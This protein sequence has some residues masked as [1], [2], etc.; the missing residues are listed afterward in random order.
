[1]FTHYR[2]SQRILPPDP[3]L[4]CSPNPTPS[5]GPIERV[6][7]Q[8]YNSP[9]MT[10]T[11]TAHA[12]LLGTLAVAALLTA[13]CGLFSSGPTPAAPSGSGS[14][15]TTPPTAITPSPS[16]TPH[17]VS[18]ITLVATLGE[19]KAATPAGLTWAGIQA[20]AG[21]IGATPTLV[22]PATRT[23]LAS[24]IDKAAGED[25]AVV[26]TVDSDATAAVLAAAASHPTTQFLEVGVTVPDG[27]PA[28]VHGL[29][30]DEAEAGYLAG[31][32]AVLYSGSRAVGV[33]GDAPTD[34]SSANYVAGFRAG[35]AQAGQ[36]STVSVG[37]AGTADAPDKGR[38]AA[39]TLIKAGSDT[40]VAMPSISGIGAMRQ[41]CA[42]KARIV[43]VDTDAW[44]TVPDVKTCLIASVLNRYDNAVG[45][46]LLALAAGTAL[47]ARVI[48]DVAN[49]GIATSDLH[50]DAP[51]GFEASLAGVMAALRSSPPRSTAAP[52]TVAPSA[53]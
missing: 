39:A 21:Q 10:R 11:S 38:T 6:A 51:A 33:V 42:L 20:T 37:Y 14:G 8:P 24:E 12:R 49:D 36:T 34:T 22:E 3:L 29:V 53:S 43:A 30:F 25:Q 13:G 47:P 40:I 32:I 18:S 44:Q 23:A 46:A 31:Y 4:K 26:V 48:N 5:S 2:R 19:P 28:N 9:T 45:A 15:A 16:P 7:Q 1:L 41:A 52:A 27:G 50:A 17:R 35:A